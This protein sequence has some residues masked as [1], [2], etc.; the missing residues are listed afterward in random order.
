MYQLLLIGL[1]V[2]IL[3]VVSMVRLRKAS[4]RP[5]RWMPDIRQVI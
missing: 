3:V 1:L 4:K 5:E 2:V